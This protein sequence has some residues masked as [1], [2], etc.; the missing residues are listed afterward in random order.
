VLAA[1]ARWARD[2]GASGACLQV[3]ADNAAG[4]ALYHA[5]GITEELHRYCYRRQPNRIGVSV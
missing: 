5:V 4:R 2:N 1:L 3:E